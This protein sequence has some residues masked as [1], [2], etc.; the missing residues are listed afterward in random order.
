MPTEQD[1]IWICLTCACHHPRGQRPPERDCAICADERQWVPPT[2]QRWGTWEQLETEYRS[3]IRTVEPGLLG[4]GV[5]PVLG[6]GQRGLLIETREGNLLWDPPGFFD[7]S[8]IQEIR[9]RG[10]IRFVTS[11]HPHMYGAMVEFA[12]LFDA[13]ILLPEV[14]AAWLQREAAAVRY[15]SG[16]WEILPGVTLV[17]CGG[18]FPGS[19]ALHWTDGA[20]GAGILLVGDTVHVTPGEDRITF[21]WSAPNRLP[22]PEREV[23]GIADALEPFEFDRIYAGWWNPVL[24]RDA[25]RILAAS[26]RRYI[27]VLYGKI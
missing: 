14:D 19:A 5:E 9:E 12:G 2:G 25:K 26:T 24:R 16:T 8:A 15:W 18:H 17:Q 1:P 22:M 13:E 21:A 7:A 23:R 27:E 4:I 3:D 10:G 6:I 20:D 11:S